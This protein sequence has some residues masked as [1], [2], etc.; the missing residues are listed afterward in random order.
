VVFTS[1]IPS[2]EI[3]AAR[4]TSRLW[5]LY[6]KTGT[7]Y[8][9]PSLERL[10]GD[11]PTFIELGPGPAAGPTLHIGENPTTTAITQ[12]PS[13]DLTTTPNNT[14]LPFKSGCLFWRKKDTD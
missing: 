13:G 12:S 2:Q 9:W 11:F 7:S 6:Y 10:G 5:S 4:G 14:P 1:F 3:C 8:F